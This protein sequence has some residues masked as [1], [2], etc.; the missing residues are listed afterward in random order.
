VTV[1]NLA[2]TAKPTLTLKGE[3]SVFVK[4]GT[5]FN[6]PGYTAVDGF[7]GDITSSVTVDYSTFDTT[8]EAKYTITYTVADTAGNTASAER[9]VTVT[10]L[11]DSVKP[12]LTLKG[13]TSV[14][15]T[16]GAN[17]SESGYTAVDGFDG[18]IT[19][20]V[21]AD[22]STL[23]TTTEAKYTITYI[24]ADTAG[25]TASAVRTVIVTDSQNNGYS[26]EF[27]DYRGCCREKSKGFKAKEH[28]DSS[29]FL[30][31]SG[32]SKDAATKH[33]ME[34]CTVKNKCTAMEI[35]TAQKKLSIGKTKEP[36]TYKCEI[37]HNY[38]NS[39]NRKNK[40]CRKAM[41]SIRD[42]CGYK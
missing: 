18:D 30:Y 28:H 40:S 5:N 26:N 36:K 23:D 31:V 4:N 33:C 25:N 35:H 20:S 37:H 38:I 16:T 14:C 32:M 27:V 41:C 15:V 17:F 1:T 2:D 9:T 10:D 7:D 34:K 19:S 42:Q 8:T 11:A 24:V 3:T 39:S 6:E 13:E 21:T 29:D 12:M 22:Y